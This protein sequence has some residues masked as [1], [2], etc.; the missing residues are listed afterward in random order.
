MVNIMLG[1]GFMLSG[2]VIA[3]SSGEKNELLELLLPDKMIE[4]ED[5]G[6]SQCVPHHEKTRLWDFDQV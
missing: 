4:H 2:L 1:L 6:V 5:Q 3:T